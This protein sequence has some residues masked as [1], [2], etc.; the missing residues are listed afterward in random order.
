[1]NGRPAAPYLGSPRAVFNVVVGGRLW[2]SLRELLNKGN[3]WRANFEGDKVLAWS[4]ADL[5]LAI[6]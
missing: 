4:V 6:I 2:N 1:M 3:L 5:R